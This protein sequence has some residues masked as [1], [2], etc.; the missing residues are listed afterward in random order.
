[1]LLGG[2]QTLAALEITQM[3]L[4]TEGIGFTF[5]VNADGTS[6]LLQDGLGWLEGIFGGN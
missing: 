3:V 2:E 1:M 4:S 5:T 6:Q